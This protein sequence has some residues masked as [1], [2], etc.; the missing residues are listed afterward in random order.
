VVRT[1]GASYGKATT[2]DGEWQSLPLR[3]VLVSI[4][5]VAVRVGGDKVPV[6]AEE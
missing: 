3:R 1:Q 2:A 6:D 4:L 5:T